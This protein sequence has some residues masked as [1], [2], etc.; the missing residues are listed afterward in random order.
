MT[1]AVLPSNVLLACAFV[2]IL[3]ETLFSAYY[4]QFFDEAFGVQDAAFVGFYVMVCRATVMF[5]APLWGYFAARGSVR[6]ILFVSQ[7]L[8]GLATCALPLVSSAWQF[9]LASVVVLVFKSGYLLLYSMYVGL[10]PAGRTTAVLRYQAIF[11]AAVIVSALVSAVLMG[12]EEPRRVFWL[13]ALSDFVMAVVCLKIVRDKVPAAVQGGSQ[14]A[15]QNISLANAPLAWGFGVLVALVF[16]FHLGVN[17]TRPFFTLFVENQHE[18]SHALSGALFLVPSLAALAFALGLAGTARLAGRSGVFGL[19]A[20]AVAVCL[21]GQAA[22]PTLWG[23]A[24]ARIAYGMGLVALQVVIEVQI[25]RVLDGAGEHRRYGLASMSQNAALLTAP[26]L[27]AGAVSG[28][29]LPAPLWTGALIFT[30]LGA[31][32]MAWWCVGAGTRAFRQSA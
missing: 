27:A 12:L 20:L 14:G 28:S 15:E 9:A 10:V 18:T 3:G 19:L 23:L 8:T 30:A 29:G 32:M 11:H 4:P 13:V 22:A 25:F 24:A 21:A 1:V 31:A 2:H 26:L 6:R 7:L 5:C 17:V 16:C